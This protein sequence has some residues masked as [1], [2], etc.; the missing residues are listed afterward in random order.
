M[1]WGLDLVVA[2]V[3]AGVA[4][5]GFGDVAAVLVPALVLGGAALAGVVFGSA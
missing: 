5:W 2:A 4:A 1:D 3:L